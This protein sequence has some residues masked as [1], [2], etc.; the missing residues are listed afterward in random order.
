MPFTSIYNKLINKSDIMSEENFTLAIDSV[1]DYSDSQNV[2]HLHPQKIKQV[3]CLAEN[4]F[5]GAVVKNTATDT[6]AS[7]Y[8]FNIY[9]V[10]KSNK[11]LQI[12]IDQPILVM[13]DFDV[14]QIES[15]AKLAGFNNISVKSASINSNGVVTKT[16]LITLTKP[17]SRAET[18]TETVTT[19]TNDGTKTVTTTKKTNIR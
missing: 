1:N 15:N 14:K 2:F 19:K 16:M 13:Q 12:Y 5:E 4:F 18:Q 17:V 7:K 3:E 9:K 10:L 11:A 8:L 6:L